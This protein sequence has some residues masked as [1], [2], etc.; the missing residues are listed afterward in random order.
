MRGADAGR[1]SAGSD[2]F[3]SAGPVA[4]GAERGTTGERAELR[5]VIEVIRSEVA[6]DDGDVAAVLGHL[7]R[8]EASLVR[9]R[10]ALAVAR[11]CGTRATGHLTRA[12]AA[13]ELLHMASLYHDDLID[14]ATERRGTV[15]AHQKWGL[16]RTVV[17]GDLL[18]ARALALAASAGHR[19]GQVLLTAFEALC[20]GQLLESARLG[21]WQRSEDEYFAATTGKAGAM[22]EASARIGALRRGPMKS[23]RTCWASSAFI[24]GSPTKCSTTSLT[25]G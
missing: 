14:E 10:L 15:A 21:D 3:V 24:S 17:G 23:G 2:A 13:L 12:A 11:A 4:T 6:D 7:L 1:S 5:A 16:A 20:R 9:P 18:V 22:F 19:Y 8:D 25:S